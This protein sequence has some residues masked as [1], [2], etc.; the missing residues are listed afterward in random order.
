MAPP[1]SKRTSSTRHPSEAPSSF[2]YTRA[3]AGDGRHATVVTSPHRPAG[4]D[5]FAVLAGRTDGSD[6]ERWGIWW[7][8]VTRQGTMTPAFRPADGSRATGDRPHNQQ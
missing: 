4:P 6:R 5:G 3:A 2:K 1:A 7:E 8:G